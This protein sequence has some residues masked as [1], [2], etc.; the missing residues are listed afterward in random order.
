YRHP[1]LVASTDS[2]GTKLLVARMAGRYRCV[3][4]DLVAMSVN[5]ILVLGAE[6]L[7]F[8]D[9]FSCGKLDPALA[10]ETIAGIADA[11]ILADCALLGGETAELPGLFASDQFDIVGFAVGVVEQHRTIDG[12]GVEP[13]DVILGLASNGLHSNG[14]SLARRVVFEAAGLK[15]ADPFPGM[16][17]SVA[18]ELLRPTRIYVR[19]V[20]RALRYY[21]VKK[22]IH[23]MAHITGGGLVGNLPRI[24]PRGCRADVKRSAWPV[25]PV[26]TYLAEAGS[27]DDEEMW[28]VFNMG[29][30][31]VLVVSPYYADHIA[32]ILRRSGEEVYKIGRIAKGNG[33]VV[34]K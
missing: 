21:K 29:I 10:S 34:I 2:V 19:S 31:F 4:Q 6:P 1:L 23:G 17:H 32:H 15:P 16:V 18:D 25:P 28:R 14:Y 11:C 8:L 33:E 26:F 3:G 30:G 9:C 24:L 12:A 20:V 7:F 5:D 27:V 13:G 22:V